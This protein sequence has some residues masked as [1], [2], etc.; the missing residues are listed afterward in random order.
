MTANAVLSLPQAPPADQLPPEIR[1]TTARYRIDLEDGRTFTLTL[2]HGRL[3]V[4]E[5]G[6]EADCVITC[7]AETF[8][9]ALAG[10]V[11]L[12]T[13]FMRSEVLMKGDFVAAKR[14]W[15]HPADGTPAGAGGPGMSRAESSEGVRS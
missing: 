4:D 6:G 11:N 3:S 15:P 13:A 7:P 12:L 2:S 10:D 5:A 1:E 8:H 14:P 9:R